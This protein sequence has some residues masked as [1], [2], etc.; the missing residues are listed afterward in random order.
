M[1]VSFGRRA[2][3]VYALYGMRGD[4]LVVPPAFQVPAPFGTSIGPVSLRFANARRGASRQP[5][6]TLARWDTAPARRE[7]GSPV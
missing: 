1:A 2:E 3:D 4:P 5:A 7:T 6:G